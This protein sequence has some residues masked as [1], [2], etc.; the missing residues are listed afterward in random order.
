MAAEQL[1]L[2][3]WVHDLA[4][5]ASFDEAAAALLR[6]VRT[7]IVGRLDA[8]PFARG[9]RM[10][11]SVVHLRPGDG[12]RG[13][14]VLEGGGARVSSPDAHDP[15]LSSTTA[16]RWVAET[17]RAV[18]IDVHVGRMAS[19]GDGGAAAAL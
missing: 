14:A 13:L 3:A 6:A 2:A 7:E 15:R 11:R 12:Y 16:W 8:S 1:D 18:S 10:V 9:G 5:A 17:R 4:H 19:L